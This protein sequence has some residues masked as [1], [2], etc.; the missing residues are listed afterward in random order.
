MDRS[1]DGYED[2][3]PEQKALMASFIANAGQLQNQ[4]TPL[5][6]DMDTARQESATLMSILV[7][8]SLITQRL[9]GALTHTRA[10][11]HPNHRRPVVIVMRWGSR[12]KVSAIA[13][14][15]F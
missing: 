11:C 7:R 13:N 2:W 3:T 9:N 1:S 10:K 15:G 4:R 5:Y 8:L 6:L 14:L 12:L